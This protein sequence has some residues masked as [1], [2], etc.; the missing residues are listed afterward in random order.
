MLPLLLELRLASLD[1]DIG[2]VFEISSSQSRACPSRDGT[3]VIK[4][5]NSLHANV[6]VARLIGGRPASRTFRSHWRKT[7][8][9]K[10]LA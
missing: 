1:L 2:D 5:R 10:T 4:R 9:P 6:A 3:Q 7:I 8:S